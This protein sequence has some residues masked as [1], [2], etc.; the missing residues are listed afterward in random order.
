MMFF[1]SFRC[2]ALCATRRLTRRP[3]RKNR[4]P[5]KTDMRICGFANVSFYREVSDGADK[6]SSDQMAVIPAAC[7]A[8]NSRPVTDRPSG[9]AALADA[10]GMI[11][12]ARPTCDECR[13]AD[14]LFDPR[15]AS[16]GAAGTPVDPQEPSVSDTRPSESG[17]LVPGPTEGRT[18]DT[19]PAPQP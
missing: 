18:H 6:R 1:P 16:P 17:P 3:E 13:R 2:D 5:R 10:S 4:H 7:V 14:T 11:R 19:Y 15:E 9:R 8:H 12:N